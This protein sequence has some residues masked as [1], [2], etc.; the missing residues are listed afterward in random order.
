MN[1]L[2]KNQ[3]LRLT[4][5]LFI[6]FSIHACGA[7]ALS[8]PGPQ[9]AL[10]RATVATVEEPFQVS[11]A[12]GDRD[13]YKLIINVSGRIRLKA[14]WRGRARELA[15]ILNGPGQVSYYARKDGR[16]PLEIDF[17]ITPKI[18]ERGSE[19][20]VSI[21]NF[22]GAGSASGTLSMEYPIESR[23]VEEPAPEPAAG[24]IKRTILKDGTVEIRYPDGTIKRLWQGGHAIIMP[25]GTERRYSYVQVQPITP[26]PPPS[27]DSMFL[28]LEQH[29]EGLLSVIRSLVDNDETAVDYYRQKE[30]DIA[31]TLIEQINCKTRYISRLLAP[32]GF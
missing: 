16:S 29:D 4:L 25:D 21:V 27:G 22:S 32:K 8:Q 31:K 7:P 28:W 11:S 26:P 17:E 19:W 20:T 23:K 1:G 5:C 6:V 2:M 10:M 14:V 12:F 13:T 9:A 24:A 30:Q 18:L 3:I 15:L